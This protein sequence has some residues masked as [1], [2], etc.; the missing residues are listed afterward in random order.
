MNRVGECSTVFACFESALR[1]CVVGV[2]HS[3]Y[4]HQLDL[5]VRQNII[6]RFRDVDIWKFLKTG[7]VGSLKDRDDLEQRN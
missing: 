2:I 1:K 5:R 7:I 4:N 6:D 3:R